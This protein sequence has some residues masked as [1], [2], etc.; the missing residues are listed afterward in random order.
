M[1]L[2]LL[3]VALVLGSA[4]YVM[5]ARGVFEASQRLVLLADDAEGVT[6]GMDISFAGFPV[7]RVQRIELGP[8]GL[9]RL[10]IDVP[11]KDAKWLRTSSV[12]T[13]PIAFAAALQRQHLHPLKP[14]SPVLRG[15]RTPA[16][17]VYR[18][19]ECHTYY[20]G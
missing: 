14:I 9:A 2:L 20:A 12:F 16:A 7:G 6:V 11:R 13:A 4:A 1:G 3:L 10:L 17:A 8:D 18:L 19:S 5:Y 15:R